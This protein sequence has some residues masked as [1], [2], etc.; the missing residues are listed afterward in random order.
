M[1]EQ[2]NE[3]HSRAR[4]RSEQCRASDWVSGAS[5][6]ASGSVLQSG[7]FAVLDYS[8]LWFQQHIC[9]LL[10][11][12]Y[13]F[14]NT[15]AVCWCPAMVSATHLPFDNAP[16]WFQQHI[17][18]LLMPIIVSSTHLP[19]V[20]AP[21]WFQPHICHFLQLISNFW[22]EDPPVLTSLP[23]SRLPHLLSQQ[24]SSWK[25]MHFSGKATL[26]E[27]RPR[28][29]RVISLQASYNFKFNEPKLV[30]HAIE[31]NLFFLW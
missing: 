18:L 29:K 4:K 19:F 25:L 1:S 23:P 16:L 9:L 24:I 10:M 5:E 6:Q 15:I 14:S 30:S 11:S 21:L 20:D 31:W 3:W 17:C 13:G 8:A 12:H 22:T 27:R 28:Q 2:A 26:S 7:F